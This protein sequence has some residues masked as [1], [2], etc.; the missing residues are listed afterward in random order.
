MW[1]HN[2]QFR[3]VRLTAVYKVYVPRVE[4]VQTKEYDSDDDEE[5]PQHTTTVS[6]D[7][8]YGWVETGN[9]RGRGDTRNVQ[10]S[11][12]KIV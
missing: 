5:A 7:D 6:Y 3:E 2:T 4:E 8:E 9:I 10:S 11:V 12:H 1:K